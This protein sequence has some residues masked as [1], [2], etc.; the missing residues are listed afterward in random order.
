MSLND[1]KLLNDFKTFALNFWMICKTFGCFQFKMIILIIYLLVS[2]CQYFES[3]SCSSKDE[4]QMMSAIHL[5]VIIFSCK[6]KQKTL[7][8]EIVG[9]YPIT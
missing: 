1:L 4:K 5:A 6:L 8:N 9:A 7:R 2:W 3:K